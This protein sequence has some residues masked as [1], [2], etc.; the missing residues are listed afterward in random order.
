M[1]TGLPPPVLLCQEC[2]RVQGIIQARPVAIWVQ[3]GLLPE[4]RIISQPALSTATP[5][6]SDNHRLIRQQLSGLLRELRSHDRSV[7]AKALHPTE[8]VWNLPP[9]G[10]AAIRGL[11]LGSPALRLHIVLQKFRHVDIFAFADLRHQFCRY[12]WKALA[13]RKR[14]TISLLGWIRL[15]ATASASLGMSACGHYRA[16]RASCL[17]AKHRQPQT[18]LIFARGHRA[19]RTCSNTASNTVNNMSSGPAREFA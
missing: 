16:G 7:C 4:H 5:G 13:K 17:C 12:G 1:S 8:Q 10:A 3:C 2:D 9:V 6:F 14:G 19:Q 18:R 15:V 11:R